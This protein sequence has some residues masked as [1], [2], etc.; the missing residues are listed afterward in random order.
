M[1]RGDTSEP[2]GQLLVK[3]SDALLHP[4]RLFPVHTLFQTW[5]IH[6]SS[7]VMLTPLL[8]LKHTHTGSQTGILHR[9]NI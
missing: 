6:N 3:P 8:T 7:A 1:C 9:S 2:A 5:W 4:G